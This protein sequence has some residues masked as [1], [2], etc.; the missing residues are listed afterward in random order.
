[1][2]VLVAAF[3]FP[4]QGQV[5]RQCQ[6][7]RDAL[8]KFLGGK[9]WGESIVARGVATNQQSFVEVF[10]NP[11]TGTWTIAA[12]S[13]RGLTCMVATGE[14]WEFLLPTSSGNDS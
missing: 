12:T 3:S 8:V 7:S 11:E 2:A 9:K 1:M 14:S 6:M 4:A 13:T 10:L 5:P